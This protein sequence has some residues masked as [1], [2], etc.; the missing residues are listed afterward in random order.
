MS[1]SSAT[2]TGLP[3]ALDFSVLLPPRLKTPPIPIVSPSP[4][5]PSPGHRDFFCGAS[6]DVDDFGASPMLG[7]HP[8]QLDFLSCCSTSLGIIRCTISRGNESRSKP[9]RYR[10]KAGSVG[11][12]DIGPSLLIAPTDSGSISASSLNSSIAL[13]AASS[14]VEIGKPPSHTSSPEGS[15]CGVRIVDS[16]VKAKRVQNLSII[17]DEAGDG[18]RRLDRGPC[19]S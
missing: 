8:V 10:V 3:F 5:S 9:T 4:P 12:V 7:T 14:E 15:G 13:F 11:G 16:K 18:G 1:R 19:R 17:V 2:E 6:F